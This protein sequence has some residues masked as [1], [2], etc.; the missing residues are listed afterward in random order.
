[1]CCDP[2]PTDRPSMRVVSQ[3]LLQASENVMEMSMP[4]LPRCKPQAHYEE[5]GFS[6]ILG[7]APLSGVGNGEHVIQASFVASSVIHSGR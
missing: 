3:L 7:N 2:N 4:R 6:Q 1:L 5:P